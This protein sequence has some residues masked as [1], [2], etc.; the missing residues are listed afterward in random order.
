MRGGGPCSV[1]N[2]VVHA[3]FA[4]LVIIRKTAGRCEDSAS[5]VYDPPVGA[6]AVLFSCTC[7]SDAACPEPG[8]PPFRPQSSPYAGNE[9]GRSRCAMLSSC[10]LNSMPPSF[11]RS[12]LGGRAEPRLPLF[13][14]YARYC[15]FPRRRQRSFWTRGI[16]TPSQ[17]RSVP[18]GAGSMTTTAGSFGN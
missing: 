10:Y 18:A 4:A 1:R 7:Q 13:F 2:D 12:S 5:E 17:A 14:F 11:Y 9:G 16:L 8:V 6:K 3:P 15:R